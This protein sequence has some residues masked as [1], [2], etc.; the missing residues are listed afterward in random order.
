MG[1]VEEI[2]DQGPVGVSLSTGS[3]TVTPDIISHIERGEEPYIRE[4][5]GSEEG[6]RGESSCSGNEDPRNSNPERHHRE[7]TEDLKAKKSLSIQQREDVSS[8]ADWGKNCISEKKQNNSTRDSTTNCNVCEESAC[9][10]TGTREEQRNQ[11][12]E[13]RCACDAHKIDLKDPV[14]LESQE[15]SRTE[16]RPSTSTDY[17]KTFSQEGELE[18]QEKTHTG[19]GFFS[20]VECR[21]DFSKKGSPEHYKIYKGDRPFS[22]TECD[23]SFITKSSLTSHQK[24]HTGE[25]EFACSECGKSFSQKTNLKIHRKIH[26][27]ERP[28]SCTECS[29]SFSQKTTLTNHQKIHTGERPFKCTEC[30]K[31]F[32]WKT[33]LQKHQNIHT[34]ER[35]FSCPECSKSFNQK[36]N[37]TRHQKIHTGERRTICMYR[38]W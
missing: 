28:F 8:C 3:L 17:G 21:N 27:G 38:M 5:P 32:T 26:T 25:R 20:S 22:C 7:L 9:N 10:I 6:E 24:I 13:Q 19:E 37:L 11:R 2:N 4:E 34:G 18:E 36:T 35:R 14:P 31:T 12:T 33:D 30:S 1:H 16:E 23:K 15:K 29:K